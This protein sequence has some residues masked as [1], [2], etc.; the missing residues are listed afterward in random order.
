MGRP[1]TYQHSDDQAINIGSNLW[2]LMQSCMELQF[3][4]DKEMVKECFFEIT[5]EEAEKI[6][7]SLKGEDTA[8]TK[9][10]ALADMVAIMDGIDSGDQEC[11]DAMARWCT[12]HEVTTNI[13][14]SGA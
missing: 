9:A 5:P 10:S 4:E 7:E 3:Y 8:A 6:L 1:S 2:G 12:Y 13:T 11:A 14:G